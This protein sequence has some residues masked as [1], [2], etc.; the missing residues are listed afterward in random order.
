LFLAGE[1]SGTIPERRSLPA[2]QPAAMNAT[3]S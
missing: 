1:R 3:A 2:S